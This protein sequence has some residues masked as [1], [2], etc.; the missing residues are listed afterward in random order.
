MN[1][2]EY[3]TLKNLLD[4]YYDKYNRPQFIPTDPISIPHLFTQ[5][6]D[7]EIAAFIA[8]TL[9]WGLRITIINNCKKILAMMHNSP[10]DFVINHKDS[11]LKSMVGFKH[12]TFNDTDLLYFMAALQNIYRH[13]GGLEACF[14]TRSID[15]GEGI[16]YFRKI[17]FSLPYAPTRTRKHVS[18]PQTGSACKRLNMYLRWMVRNDGRGVDFGIWK[19]ISPAQLI[20]PCDVHVERVARQLMLITRKQTDWATAQELTQ[21]LKILDPHDPVKYDYALFGI[22][23]DTKNSLR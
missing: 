19:S 12:R 15:I 18:S 17:F 6:E 8:A 13:H 23:L 16:S 1:Q 5:K 10:Y 22:G 14:A 2:T 4:E 7:I 11:D 20:C 3:T 21:N 9:S